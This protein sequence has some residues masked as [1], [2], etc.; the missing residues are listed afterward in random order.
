MNREVNQK[1]SIEKQQT[2]LPVVCLKDED[3]VLTEEAFN[4]ELLRRASADVSAKLLAHD[5]YFYDLQESILCGLNEE[6]INS[7]K[8]DNLAMAHASVKSIIN[9]CE[10]GHE[11]IILIFAADNE[12]VGSRTQQGANSLFL[13]QALECIC[14]N[15]GFSQNE[16][17]QALDEALFISADLAHAVHPHYPNVADPSHR[18]QMNRGPVIKIAANQSYASD[19][20]SSARF[21]KACI[22][23]DIPYQIFVN[24][25]DRPGGST[26]GPITTAYLTM[27]TVD[28]GN[29]IWAM[30]S[31]RETGSCL[32]HE[33]MIK[34]L[35]HLLLN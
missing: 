17:L 27:P 13:R 11:G 15:V 6:F 19:S 5:L 12:E 3:K 31:I 4:Q 35:T 14:N 16:F 22:D 30:H 1:L 21:I 7:P 20:K 34:A 18:P 9:A 2:L 8:L 23:A 10:S 28:I 24:H 29:A 25:S 26:I 33:Y 32:D